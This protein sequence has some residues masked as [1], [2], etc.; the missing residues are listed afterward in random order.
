MTQPPY[1]PW[2]QQPPPGGYRPPMPPPRPVAPPPYARPLPPGM[3]HPQQT[4]GQAQYGY[5]QQPWPAYRPPMPPKSNAG[6]ITAVSLVGVLILAA[7]LVGAFSIA[8]AYDDYNDVG[9]SSPT[10][11]TYPSYTGYSSASD[12]PSTTSYDYTSTTTTTETTTETTDYTTT[13]ETPSGPQPVYTLADNPLHGD[14]G[15]NA[16]SCAIS[17]WPSDPAA[18][19]AFFTRVL[20]CMEEAWAPAMERAGLP[21]ETPGLEFP[22]GTSWESPCGSTSGATAAAFYCS[23]N[24]TIYMPFEGLQTGDYGNQ[25]GYYLALFGHEFGHH[26]QWL[27]GIL[28]TYHEA[29]YEAGDQTAAGLELSR[30]AELQ[31]S[32]LGG[33]W[34]AGAWNGD[35]GVPDEIVRQFLADGYQ[36]GDWN[37]N[38]P[39]D[40]GSPENNG[41]WQEHGYRNNRGNYCNT[42]AADSQHVA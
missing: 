6:V 2:H 9:Y 40:H 23:R 36:R 5:A 1:G 7:G 4:Y 38:L 21:Y 14:N 20:P 24:N 13:T 15:T 42:W 35:A 22:S 34:F 17:G 37:A 28:P 8:D 25:P 30:R 33:M 3:H 11:S 16:A 32:C 18:A 26:I 31:A 10:Y 27:S 39:R 19:K 41:S 29:K 12:Y